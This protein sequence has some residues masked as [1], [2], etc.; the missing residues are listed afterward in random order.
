MT[1]TGPGGLLKA[2]TKIV[3]V[4]ALEEETAEHLGYDKSTI[5]SVGSAAT[6][7]KGT[8]PV[9]NA[10]HSPKRSRFRDPPEVARSLPALI[11]LRRGLRRVPPRTP[12]LPS[13][14]HPMHHRKYLG[15]A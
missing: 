8:R 6:P 12:K 1:L 4:T 2:L 13:P 14:T 11:G 10:S 9:R 7:A 15:S 3:I 5:R